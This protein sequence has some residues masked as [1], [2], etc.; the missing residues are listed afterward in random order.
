MLLHFASSYP[1]CFLLVS[2]SSVRFVCP[3]RNS[4]SLV[5]VC[6]P[7]FRRLFYFFK[8]SSAFAITY[9]ITSVDLLK[10]GTKALV[11]VP[12]DGILV[13]LG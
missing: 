4:L 3:C 13:P 12:L 8:T 7:L 5:I 1:F 11:P 10:S 9:H 6:S 2:G